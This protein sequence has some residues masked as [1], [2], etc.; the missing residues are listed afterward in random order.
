MRRTAKG[1]NFIN[2][3]TEFSQNIIPTHYIEFQK[4]SL[5]TF[6]DIL[7]TIFNYDFFQRTN[8]LDKKKKIRVSYFFNWNPSIKF[9]NPSMQGS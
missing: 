5:N 8:M 6:Q 7:L 1:R 4:P 9:Q 2:I 3:F